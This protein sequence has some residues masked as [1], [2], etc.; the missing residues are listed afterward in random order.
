[1]MILNRQANSSTVPTSYIIHTSHL[2]Y[3]PLKSQPATPTTPLPPNR[4]PTPFLNPNFLS[5][6]SPLI[7]FSLITTACLN[8]TTSKNC[9]PFAPVLPISANSL[10]ASS[11]SLYL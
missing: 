4:P 1:M 3:Q 7:P 11:A 5:I 10:S 6:S 8:V 2:S 9:L